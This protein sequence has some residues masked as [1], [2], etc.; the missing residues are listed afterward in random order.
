MLL[1][2]LYV[3]LLLYYLLDLSWRRFCSRQAP[4]H[5]GGHLNV[6]DSLLLLAVQRKGAKGLSMDRYL[7]TETNIADP[8]VHVPLAALD[9]LD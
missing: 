1:R 8:F 7:C 4:R 5:T 3:V 6:F 2:R 9:L